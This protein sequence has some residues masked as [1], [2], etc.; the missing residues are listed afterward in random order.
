VKRFIW[1]VLFL[2][3]VFF[4]LRTFFIRRIGIEKVTCTSS[5]GDCPLTLQ[6]H[7][8]GMQGKPFGEAPGFLRD[9]FSHIYFTEHYSY[10]LV[11]PH[12]L[13]VSVVSSHPYYCIIVGSTRIDVSDTNIVLAL[14]EEPGTDCLRTDMNLT[15]G[16]GKPLANEYLFAAKLSK[17]LTEARFAHQFV[18]HDTSLTATFS[19]RSVL[20][21][22]SGDIP[23]LVGATE[24]VF[25]RL[26]TDET[27]SR[28]KEID[29]R[30][31][32]PVLR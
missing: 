16:L 24:L 12:E 7:L 1:L 2:L 4:G 22:T 14:L 28:I 6:T 10:Q 25:S 11:P 23:Y 17:A 29:L 19:D 8:R 18:I 5:A 31:T 26:N 27:L 9:V 30:Y 21:P 15:V 32:Q 3:V 13:F 20:Y